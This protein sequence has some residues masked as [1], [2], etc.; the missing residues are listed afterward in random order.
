MPWPALGRVFRALPP[1]GFTASFLPLVMHRLTPFLST[2]ALVLLGGTACQ[3]REV[4][5]YSAP[6]EPTSEVAPPMVEAERN[7]DGASL[8]AKAPSPSERAPLPR[9]AWT[10]PAGWS[11]TEAGKM[12][13]ASFVAAGKSGQATVAITP[14]PDLAGREAMI[15]NMWRAQAGAAELDP[16]QAEAALVPVE[17]AGKEGKL[18]EVNGTRDGKATRIVTAMLNRPDGTW[19][20][21]LQ[22]DDGAVAEQKPAF[23]E[24]LKSVRFED[25]PATVAAASP[26]APPPVPSLPLTPPALT[27]PAD[28]RPLPTG[29]MQ[30]AKYAVPD[31]GSAKAEVAVSMFNS[32]TGGATAN[33][34]RWRR[35]LGLP[36]IPEPEVAGLAQPLDSALPGA[37]VADLQNEQRRM[38]GAIVPRA[39]AWWFYKLSG[40]A[41]AV[42]AARDSFLL[43]AR[44][45][46]QT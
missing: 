8:D 19:F 39:G 12:S 6:K 20:F 4:T 14:L 15:V 16:A 33:I 29:Q 1:A 10:L 30:V 45:P 11:Q 37:L 22:G 34:I 18:F 31:A 21:K 25:Q 46:P 23:L 32:D 36:E 17:A 42:A 38:V 44:Q 40:D 26:V 35:Q 41:A 24:F 43:F 3:R 27:P 7:T 2:G 5:V 9:M 13:A 28:W